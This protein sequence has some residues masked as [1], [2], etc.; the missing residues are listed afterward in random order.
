[1]HELDL[2]SDPIYEEQT[3]LAERE[4]SSFIAAVTKLFGPEQAKLSAT[5][6]STNRNSWTARLDLNIE[7]G[8]RSRSRL[9][10]A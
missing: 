1:M 8:E 10:L 5:I 7:I 6:G 4:L 2:F 9:R 3:Y